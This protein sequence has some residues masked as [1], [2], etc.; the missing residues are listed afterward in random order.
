[1]FW[2][3]KEEPE[4]PLDTAL[5]FLVARHDIE[6]QATCMK[7]ESVQPLYL[8]QMQ[9]KNGKTTTL[10]TALETEPCLFCETE[11]MLKVRVVTY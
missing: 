9:E 1:M 5:G 7:C 3:K 4:P 8:K 2:M 6:L 10:R 11:G